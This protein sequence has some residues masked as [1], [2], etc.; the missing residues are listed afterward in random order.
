MYRDYSCTTLKSQYDSAPTGIKTFLRDMKEVRDLSD[1]FYFEYCQ[2]NGTF[3]SYSLQMPPENRF[4]FCRFEVIDMSAAFDP[5]GV[6]RGAQRLKALQGSDMPSGTMAT[7]S[8]GTCPTQDSP[9]YFG[10]GNVSYGV[11][12]ALLATW[13]EASQ[14][15]GALDAALALPP[16]PPLPPEILSN[17]SREKLDSLSPDYY[18]K[19]FMRDKYGKPMRIQYVG[20]DDGFNVYPPTYVLDIKKDAASTWILH[21]ELTDS[22]WKIVDIV[23]LI[24]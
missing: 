23:E 12:R 22:G 9:S 4:G 18:F 14:S 24:A 13:K 5:N 11:V 6:Y 1:G 15:E 19:E 8:E 16:Q 21:F 7:P 17:L 10:V 2:G 20:F 3:V